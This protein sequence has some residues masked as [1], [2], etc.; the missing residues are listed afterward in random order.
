M[1]PDDPTDAA[2]AY[3]RGLRVG[4]ATVSTG[5]ELDAAP[6]AIA[7]GPVLVAGARVAGRYRIVRLLGRGGM[8][9]VYEAQDEALGVDVALKALTPERAAR[10]DGDRFDREVTLARAIAHPNVCRT[11]DLTVDADGRRYVTMELVAGPS[12]ADR[13]RDGPLPP[14]EV[15][16][17]VD[18]LIAGLGAAHAAGVIHR[19]LKPGNVLFAGDRPVITDFGLAR[20]EGD[21]R[22]SASDFAGTPAYMAPE[23]MVGRRVSTAVDVYALGVVAF[24]MLTGRL[25]FSAS[26]AATRPAGALVRGPLPS[27]GGAA[28]ARWDRLIA[29]CTAVEPARRP[30]AARLAALRRAPPRPRRSIAARIGAAALATIIGGA[31]LV[32]TRRGAP[33]G[34]VRVDG[35]RIPLAYTVG[36]L[37][38]DNVNTLAWY[39]AHDLVLGGYGG[40]GAMLGQ[41]ALG[42][43]PRLERSGWVA[44]VDARGLP[45]WTW[46]T[47]ASNDVRVTDVAVT[48]DGDVVAT[49]WYQDEL[50][51]GGQ[52]LPRPRTDV[53]GFV[54]RLD[55]ATG[56]P[57]WIQALG[58][59]HSGAPRAIEVDA[60]GTIYVAGEYG[61]A[62]TFGGGAIVA[63]SGGTREA[64]APFV[65]AL[66]GAGQRRWVTA[67]R[68]SAARMFGLCVADGRVFLGG[69]VWSHTTLGDRALGAREIG[70]GVV[71]ALDA[72]TGAAEWHARIDSVRAA[73]VA[74]CRADGDRLVVAGNFQRAVTLGGVAYAT[75]GSFGAWIA[76]LDPATG[77]ARWSTAVTGPGMVNP[78]DVALDARGHAWVIGKFTLE[79]GDAPHRITSGGDEDGFVLELDPAGRTVD[80]ARIGGHGGERL[81]R[82]AARADGRLAIGG[83]YAGRFDAGG[84]ALTSRGDTDGLVIELDPGAP[85]AP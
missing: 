48:P 9:E 71:V 26:S 80:L 28:A 45:R 30:T 6:P 11:F 36:G 56:R 61:G 62:A 83:H 68:G 13:L 63:D 85:I 70:D 18:G 64:R 2:A 47:A 1:H 77:A 31:A 75:A 24:E 14:A 15:G 79:A 25:P 23:Q 34:V 74:A 59:H 76:E 37:G 7:T 52:R 16:A 65:L 20:H 51:A 17:I 10:G 44:R 32:A 78:S 27:V 35:A 49:G 21:E 42:R 53:D 41:A 84:F 58:I 22:A 73:N 72:A 3:P 54:V 82:I 4:A 69:I 33:A 5:G 46:R 38:R 39:D 81:R 67:G 8:G 12:L 29:A 50:D 55:G 57:R 60:A 43:D 66:D 19:D 40:P